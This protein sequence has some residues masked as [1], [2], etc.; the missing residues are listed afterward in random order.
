MASFLG[1]DSQTYW[2][3]TKGDEAIGFPK[4][5]DELEMTHFGYELGINCKSRARK[6]T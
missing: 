6:K 3:E 5:F 4:P 2:T 1:Q